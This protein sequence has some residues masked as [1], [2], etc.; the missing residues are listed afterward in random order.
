MDHR[1]TSQLGDLTDDVLEGAHQALEVTLET[2]GT[3]AS[4]VLRQLAEEKLAKA[5]ADADA[6]SASRFNVAARALEELA[7]KYDAAAQVAYISRCKL[8]E[9]IIMYR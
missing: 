4:L 7:D 1:A 9:M 3:G 6:A 8:L 5:R 2:H